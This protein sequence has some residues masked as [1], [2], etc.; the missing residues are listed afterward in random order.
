MLKYLIDYVILLRN[1]QGW[2]I[3]FSLN[4]Q[5]CNICLECIAIWM[6]HLIIY[7]YITFGKSFLS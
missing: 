2:I 1:K 6:L 7:H 5:T 3:L 4:P